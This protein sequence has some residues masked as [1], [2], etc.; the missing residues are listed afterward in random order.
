MSKDNTNSWSTDSFIEEAYRKL[1]KELER[2][3]FNGP[4]NEWRGIYISHPGPRKVQYSVRDKEVTRKY[5]INADAG[6]TILISIDW[7]V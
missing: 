6:K 4:T 5:E 1:E 2:E 3:V 7:N